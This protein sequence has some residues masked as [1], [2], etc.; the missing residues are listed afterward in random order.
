MVLREISDVIDDY[1]GNSRAALEYGLT[2]KRIVDRAKQP[3]FSA[4]SWAPLAALVAVDEFERVG[5]FKEVMTWNE[6]IGFLTTWAPS[7]QWDCSFKRVTETPGLVFLELE[8]RATVG[9]HKNTVNSVS[10]YAFDD[11][12]KIR[13]I[14][15]YLQM[16]LPEAGLLESYDGIKISD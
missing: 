13:H 8:E 10:V 6:Y 2:T 14:D 3:G 11:A 12:G 9:D 4:E 7:A 5:N 1:T 15:V 16:A